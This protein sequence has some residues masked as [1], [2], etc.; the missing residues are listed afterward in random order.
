MAYRVRNEEV[1]AIIDTSLEDVT[2]FIAG[3][4]ALVDQVLGTDTDLSTAQLKEI[5]RWLAAHFVAIR[6]PQ[7]RSEKIGEASISY[8]VGIAGEGLKATS[9]GQQVLALDT[10]GKF[11][12]VGKKKA[13]LVALD[14]D[15]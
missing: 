12:A 4:N 7:A 13:E 1:K 10:S 5:E 15:L 9:W 11:L 3:A 8:Q 2:P 6:D 14:L